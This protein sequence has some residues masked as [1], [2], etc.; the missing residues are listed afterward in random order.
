MA[1]TGPDK[2]ARGTSSPEDQVL[3]AGDEIAQST[4]IT[5]AQSDSLA[6]EP[7]STPGGPAL[8][9]TPGRKLYQ[10]EIY[11]TKELSP[12]AVAL[13]DTPEFQR[14]SHIYQLG[15]THTVFRGANH[16]RFEHSVGAYF[17][18]RTMLRRIVQNH[19]RFHRTDPEQYCHPGLWLSPRLYLEVPATPANWQTPNSPMGRW[20]GLVEI[21]SA[22]ALLHDLGHVPVGHTM[23]D[24]FTVFRKH[25]SLGGPRLF[26]MLYGP[27]QARI[28][29]QSATNGWRIENFFTPID[30]KRLRRPEPWQRVPLPWALE[31]GTYSRFLPDFS[32]NNQ[33]PAP[34][35]QNWEIRDLI[36]LILSFKETVDGEIG[37]VTYKTF[38][39]ELK[40]AEKETKDE[41]SRQRVLFIKALYEHYSQPVV[42]SP[43]N[44]ALPLFHPFMSDAVGNTICADLLDYLVR[45]GKRLKLDERQ[46]T[47]SALLGYSTS[48]LQRANRNGRR[49]QRPEEVID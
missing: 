44:E 38:E 39:D 41:D 33:P 49:N 46:P 28:G 15:F 32:G 36:Y 26:E 24:E 31:I 37:H 47:T 16:R 19:A 18:V 10:D 1:K 6:R 9:K 13:I 2:T 48:L 22:A 35:L 21:V 5:V 20:R 8:R 4:D 29:P 12:L 30:E 23:E 43:D 11:G 17:M 3:F 25:D 27:R 14:L 42:I 7:M 45:D 34:G 40:A